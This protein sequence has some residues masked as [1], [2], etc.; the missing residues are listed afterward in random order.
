MIRHVSAVT[1]ALCLSAASLAAQAAVPQGAEF[2]VKTASADVHKFPSMGS[3]V[4]G[5]APRGTALAI[6]RNLGS[7]VEVPWPAGEGGVAF[8]HVN[9]GSIARSAL[10]D[11]SP[12]VATPAPPMPAPAAPITSAAHA[13]QITA[14]NQPPSRRRVYIS[15]PSHVVGL[16]G[17][18][19]ASAP[20]FG[21]TAR[22]WWGNRLGLQFEVSRH[23]QDSPQAAGRVTSIQFAPSVLY[24]LPDKVTDQLWVRPYLAGGGGVYRSTLAGATSGLEASATDSGL[25][26]QAFGGG[27]VTIA[28]V[29]Q[30]ALSA[31]IGY[32]WAQTSFTGFE[33]NKIGFSLSGHWYVK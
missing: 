1:I 27:E 26:F 20:G 15:V 2:S 24:L 9:T 10:P 17:S 16:G 12:I 23:A 28:G 7:W 30:F 19:S 4:I 13:E 33:P 8:L 3:P 6:T 14:V 22:K 29:P 18:L 32:R 11:P 31:D 5:T 25:G 21:A